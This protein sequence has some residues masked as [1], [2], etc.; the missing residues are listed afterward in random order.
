MSRRH[1][2]TFAILILC[3]MPWRFVLHRLWVVRQRCLEGRQGV[4][5]RQQQLRLRLG[6]WR[7]LWC[8]KKLQLLRQV[9]MRRYP[10]Q[11][12]SQRQCPGGCK[13]FSKKVVHCRSYAWQ[14]DGFCD[15]RNNICGCNWDGV[16]LAFKILFL[17]SSVQRIC[18]SSYRSSSNSWALQELIFICF[19]W[20]QGLEKTRP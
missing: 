3:V 18:M 14:G 4:W 1:L 12:R 6:R 8:R 13:A 10:V 19:F 7:L 11:T 20:I 2:L 17:M 5:R 9:R 15:A 16:S